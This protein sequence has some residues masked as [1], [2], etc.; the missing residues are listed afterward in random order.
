MSD[1][2]VLAYDLHFPQHHEPSVNALLEFLKVN[3]PKIKGFL[4][5]GDQLDLGCVSHHN[6]SKSRLRTRGGLKS[7][8]DGFDALLTRIEKLLPR[9][10]EK[11]F[12]TGN[13]EVWISEDLL[14]E[15]PELEGMISIESYL[16]LKERGWKVVP[17]GGFHKVGHL[18]CIHG[19]SV[20]GG[21]NAAK[22][23]AEV[24][25]GCSVVLGH[26]HTLQQWTKAS[27]A[28]SE[29]RWIATVLP[30]LGTTAPAY[31]RGRAN[32]HLNGFGLVELRRDKSF[33]L[34]PIVITK[35]EF[36]FSGRD[37]GSSK[38]SKQRGTRK[39][40]S[41]QS[42]GPSAVSKG[43]SAKAKPKA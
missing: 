6:K 20:G 40:D 39:K 33:N 22:K 35:G 38:T 42:R 25:S 41:P 4:W 12:L 5:G 9:D 1:L 2:Y 14:D 32:T 36:S 21:Q 17:Q 37:Y 10:A 31:G 28:H 18:Y 16:R 7:D 8:L 19:D 43:V 24:Y 30:T 23:A 13:H 34:Y 27:P 26:H 29:D 11:I 15:M 3:R